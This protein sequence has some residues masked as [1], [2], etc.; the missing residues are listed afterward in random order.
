MRIC[1]F[2]LLVIATVTFA[3]A[4]ESEPAAEKSSRQNADQALLQKK[5]AELN[6]LQAEIQ[7]LKKK[8]G[9]EQQL[10]IQVQ[11]LEAR[12]QRFKESGE[13]LNLD[14]PGDELQ[15]RIEQ[16]RRDKLVRILAEPQLVT[17][18]GR[19]ASFHVGGRF[20]VGA[21]GKMTDFGERFDVVAKPND[22]GG[23]RLELHAHHSM[24]DFERTTTVDGQAVPSLI[25]REIDTSAE[26]R[27][28]Q[29][30]AM[31]SFATE[32][33]THAGSAETS[34]PDRADNG[35]ESIEFIVLVT[36]QFVDAMD[37][38]PGP[39]DAK[40]GYGRPSGGA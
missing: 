10:L 2:T 16:W 12:P 17:L 39:N 19:P 37:P 25:V 31:A 18:L 22:S 35:T 6:E 23:I 13:K 21:A 1:C 4:Q 24:L 9:Q 8:L 32:R 7:A 38:A 33:T 26:L 40:S 15:K 34:P 29:T 20:P 27:P 5:L 30:L 28:D 3:A 14:G 11:M 36:V